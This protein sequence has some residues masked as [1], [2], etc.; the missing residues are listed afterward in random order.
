M[1]R[2][3]FN[4]RSYQVEFNHINVSPCSSSFKTTVSAVS[5]AGCKEYH[6]DSVYSEDSGSQPCSEVATQ[7]FGHCSFWRTSQYVTFVFKSVCNSCQNYLM[8]T[9]NSSRRQV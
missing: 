1:Q 8:S 6:F 7:V 4:F 2:F 3:I 5:Q 9:V